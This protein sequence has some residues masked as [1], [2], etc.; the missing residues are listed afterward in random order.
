MR[1]ASLLWLP[2]VVLAAGSAVITAARTQQRPPATYTI[3]IDKMAFGTAPNGLRVGDTIIWV[4]RDVFRHTATAADHSFNVDLA[5]GKSG[6]TVLT[7]AGTVPFNCTF[8]PGMRGA[9][10]IAPRQDR[11]S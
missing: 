7:R 2:V 6:P 8:H 3:V 4:N 10:T 11:G 9:L 1:R 5:S